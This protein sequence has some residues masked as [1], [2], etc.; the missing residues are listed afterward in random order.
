VR[1]S[2]RCESSLTKARNFILSH[3]R[4]KTRGYIIV[5]LASVDAA[6]DAHIFVEPDANAD[7]HI[8]WRWQGIYAAS[9]PNFVAGEISEAADIRGIEPHRALDTDID[10]RPGTRYLLFLDKNGDE[11]ER[12]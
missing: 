10:L 1:D 11:V 7:W 4:H 5:K 2:P 8:V 6:S 9:V 3:W 12:L